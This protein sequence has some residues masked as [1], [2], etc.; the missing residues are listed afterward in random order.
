M[1][2]HDLQLWTRIGAKNP[3]A[4]SPQPSPPMGERE[5]TDRFTG[6]GP[7]FLTPSARLTQRLSAPHARGW[8]RP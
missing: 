5:K 7:A 4:P 2:S 8:Y 6:W 1:G 3:D